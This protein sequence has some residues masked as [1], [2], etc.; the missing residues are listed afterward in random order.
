MN[1]LTQEN[2]SIKDINVK[3][4]QEMIF[5][6]NA[7]ENGWRVKKSKKGLYSFKKPHNNLEEY[8]SDNFISTF[9][10]GNIN[11]KNLCEDL[12]NEIE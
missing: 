3:K 6:Y 2:F 12:S 4:L 11:L 8:F 7:L 9:I 10:K 5:I 1:E